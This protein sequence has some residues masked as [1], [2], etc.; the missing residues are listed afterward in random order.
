MAIRLRDHLSLQ[1]V[2]LLFLAAMLVLCGSAGQAC[3]ASMYSI[4]IP[5]DPSADPL[6]RF[7]RGGKAGYID[8]SGKVVIAPKFGD[9]YGPDGGEFHDGLLKIAVGGGIYIDRTGKIAI[10]R[11]LYQ[12]GDF[13][14]G[15]AAA[16]PKDRGKWGYIG[17]KGNFVISPRF[18]RSGWP[19]EGG[20]AKIEVKGRIG[21]ISHSGE[22]AISPRFL[23]AFDFHDG[24]A[25]VVADGP[26]FYMDPG[27]CPSPR[28]IPPETKGGPRPPRC[29]Y[30]F[31]DKTGS[32]LA[33]R[34]FEFAGD[35][36][37][38]MAPVSI[39]ELSGFINKAGAVVIQPRFTEA[40]SFSDGLALVSDNGRYGYVD[41]NGVYVIR[42]QFEHA[43][44][45]A[46]GRA[47]VGDRDSTSFWYIDRTGR[48]VIP[49][50]FAFFKGLA[51]VRLLTAYRKDDKGQSVGNFAYIDRYG[52]QV[53]SYIG[54]M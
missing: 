27:Y 18:E 6:Y 3:D 36:S 28:V 14:E 38:G 26:C 33:N 1:A 10:D 31:V 42:P 23:E 17:P 16:T 5:R 48:Q 45:F 13:S 51:H 11:G 44:S 29:K 52:R 49:G 40:Y 8:R 20:F 4:W 43:E 25:R 41:R 54:D 46:E 21:F 2:S 30:V 15:L 12:G 34:R 53:F 9:V 47:V 35:F 32:I 39:G 50:K 19:F 37:E 7:M 24:M 22:F